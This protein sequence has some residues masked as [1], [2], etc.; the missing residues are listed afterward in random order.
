MEKIKDGIVVDSN[1]IFSALIFKDSTNRKIL[2][3][4][5]LFVT[6]EYAL[7][8]I[9]VHLPLIIKKCASRKVSEK[10]VRFAVDTI[11]SNIIFIPDESYKPFIKEAVKLMKNIDEKDSPFIAVAMAL[12]LPL[13]SNDKA[14][15]KQK[16]VP[17]YST[18]EI[19]KIERE[20]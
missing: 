6:P 13:W 1:I 14:L 8:E 12:N 15:K 16:R 17:I 20:R 3:K 5:L 4:P 18:E 11:L 10:E 2:Q 19:L 9:E 7:K